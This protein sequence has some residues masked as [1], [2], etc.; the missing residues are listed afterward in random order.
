MD[1]RNAPTE[2]KCTNELSLILLSINFKYIEEL[3]NNLRVSFYMGYS[4]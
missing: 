4:N 2:Y 3:I 1:L